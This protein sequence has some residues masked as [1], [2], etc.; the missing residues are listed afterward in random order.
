MKIQTKW[1]NI[2]VF[3]LYYMYS[4]SAAATYDSFLAISTVNVKTV[5]QI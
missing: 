4:K 3:I 1:Q 5:S 2:A